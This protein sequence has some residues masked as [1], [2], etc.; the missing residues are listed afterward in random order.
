MLSDQ[1]TEMKSPI[2][3]NKE[4]IHQPTSDHLVPSS[5]KGDNP[6]GRRMTTVK[7]NEEKIK[8]NVYNYTQKKI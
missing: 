5:I 7:G 3:N 4:K 8:G 6:D 1:V 2:R